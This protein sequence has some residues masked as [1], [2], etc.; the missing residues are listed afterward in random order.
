MNIKTAFA[1]T[2]L[3]FCAINFAAADIVTFGFNKET[4]NGPANED[5]ASQ[6][7]VQIWDDTEAGVPSG[8]ILFKFVNDMDGTGVSGTLSQIY[9]DDNSGFLSTVVSPILS[10]N[11]L[12]TQDHASGA[13]TIAYTND[14]N[15]NN[16]DK[17]PGVAS[18][19]NGVTDFNFDANNPAQTGAEQLEMA[20][21][22]FTLNGGTFQ[23]VRDAIENGD[24][25][26]AFH[27]QSIGAT[28]NSDSFLNLTTAI[29]V[30]E[31]SS[32]LFLCTLGSLFCLRIR[33]A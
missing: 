19:G 18:W 12:H 7:S 24:L 15:I 2:V 5:F 11:P 20:G 21:F 23:D 6:T 30:P 1:T 16:S 9:W 33:R 10:N 28:D 31:P 25:R 32:A 8:S 4:N 26:V 13:A 27:A 3:A 29:V 14:T 17:P 22:L